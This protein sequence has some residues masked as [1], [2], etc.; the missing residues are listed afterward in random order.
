MAGGPGLHIESQS[1][2]RDVDRLNRRGT[3]QAWRRNLQGL[4]SPDRRVEVEDIHSHAQPWNPINPDA[5][6]STH[7]SRGIECDVVSRDREP[8]QSRFRIMLRRE[9]SASID[10]SVSR[11]RSE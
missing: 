7:D 3:M 1:E 6:P 2:H 5:C 11:R 10:V 4:S 9:R 8:R